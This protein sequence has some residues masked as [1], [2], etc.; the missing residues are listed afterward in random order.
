MSKL[1]QLCTLLVVLL[2]AVPVFAQSGRGDQPSGALAT[3][4]ECSYTIS[5]DTSIYGNWDEDYTWFDHD[6]YIDANG[7]DVDEV[8]VTFFAADENFYMPYWTLDLFAEYDT[9][10]TVAVTG[11]KWF[12]IEWTELDSITPDTIP[13][14]SF[15]TYGPI[16]HDEQSSFVIELKDSADAGWHNQFHSSSG[17][18]DP[19]TLN[20]GHQWFAQPLAE[21]TVVG[22]DDATGDTVA[23]GYRGGTVEIPIWLDTVTFDIWQNIW[24]GGSGY[25]EFTIGIDN[26]LVFE[27]FEG[28]AYAGTNFTGDTSVAG[29]VTIGYGSDEFATVP[30]GDALF[31]TLSLYVDPN[32]AQEDATYRVWIKGIQ[33]FQGCTSFGTTFT[34]TTD[35]VLVWVPE[36]EASWK[37]ASVLKCRGLQD[38]GLPFYLST[39]A[40]VNT[41]VAGQTVNA[42][43]TWDSSYFDNTDFNQVTSEYSYNGGT[44]YW[45]QNTI[46]NPPEVRIYEDPFETSSTVNVT[47]D[48][49]AVGQLIVDL[50]DAV[51]TDSVVF[52]NSDTLDNYVEF[53][54]DGDRLDGLDA[55][56]TLVNGAINTKTCYDPGC[57]ALYVWTGKAFV[58]Q[59]YILTHSQTDLSATAADDYLPIASGIAE[60]DGYFRIQIREFENEI[61]FLDQ[62][63]LI[64]AEYPGESEI[65]ISVAGDVFTHHEELKPIAAV[66]GFG[67][68]VLDLVGAEDGVMFEA[69]GPGSLTLT[70]R[71]KPGEKRQ[72]FGVSLLEAPPKDIPTPSGTAKAGG[73]GDLLYAE[74]ED[75]NGNWQYLGGIPPRGHSTA[76]SQWTF[77]SFGANLDETFRVKIS[78]TREYSVDCQTL[79]VQDNANVIEHRLSPIEASHTTAGKVVS[80]LTGTDAD[81]ITLSPGETV[82]L[83]FKA[84]ERI[85]GYHPSRAFYLKTH[86][87]YESMAKPGRAVPDSYVLGDNYPNPFNPSTNIG[88][89]LPQRQEV[90]LRVF[91]LLGQEVK[92][93]FQGELDQGRHVLTWNGDNN[94]G[95][96]VASG[97]YF[98]RLET[99]EFTQSKKMML[100]K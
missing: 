93:V 56:M 16:C 62:V 18:Q 63:E 70:Y 78:W 92:T 11:G 23:S 94:A 95:E 60:E 33:T 22:P 25:Y 40:L 45:A 17:V 83:A 67:N 3:C 8:Y 50:A 37:F 14:F 30:A 88:L 36:K 20:D 54:Y 98:Y 39:T 100:L 35:T 59:D 28:T 42:A 10:S 44:M 69:D 58:L 79:Q 53:T 7:Q 4:S 13:F 68:D 9:I 51:Y 19:A 87:Y 71:G 43:F 91:N 85:R 55:N 32:V 48:Y 15:S 12:H 99:K 41:D 6:F 34:N 61:T 80:S 29:E 5:G 57:P 64:V 89:S 65:G 73:T 97:V 2:L 76:T 46:S 77:D 21:I 27:D 75:A 49:E 90:T 72:G 47:G 24:Q 81:I 31:G 1:W 86:G 74:I 82:E 96:S 26:G 84:P 66:D 52:V 38:Y